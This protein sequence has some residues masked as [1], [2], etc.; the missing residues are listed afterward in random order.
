MANLGKAFQT[1]I[2]FRIADGI[3]PQ[4][5]AV[6]AQDV[7]KGVVYEKNGAKITAFEVEHATAKP[8]FGYRVDYGGHSVVLSGDTFE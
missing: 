1:D 8:A 2:R 6:L 4:G 5:V 7:T 3:P